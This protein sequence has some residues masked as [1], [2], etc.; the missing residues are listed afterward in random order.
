MN[1]RL[2]FVLPDVDTSLLVERDLL[3]A[4]VNDSLMHFMG[5]RGT[6]LK[7]LPEATTI[8]KSDIIHGI[9]VGMFSG[10]LG[11][12]ALG[13]IIYVA[14]DFIGMQI[15]PGIILIFFL[16]GSLLGVWIGGL[17]IGSSTPNITLH[18]FEHTM[19]EGH[20]LL[21]VDVS[22]ERVDE[23]REIVKSHFPQAED[24]GEEAIFHAFP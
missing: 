16:G 11:G 14:R 9:K 13:A 2:Y 5:K 8:Q 15:V 20:I 1:R 18:E 24:H 4:K 3:L 7:D 22:V 12:A 19:D 6:D 21:M 23:I 17:L 10:A